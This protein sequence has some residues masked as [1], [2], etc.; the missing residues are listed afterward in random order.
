M[1]WGYYGGLQDADLNLT[2]YVADYPGETAT[3]FGPYALNST[4]KF[5]TPRFRGRLMSIK[6]ESSDAGSFWR[7]GGTRYRIQQDGKF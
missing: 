1:K 3:V 7:I 6:M 5:V 4:T 2:F